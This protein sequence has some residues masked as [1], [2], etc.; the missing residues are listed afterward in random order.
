MARR[1]AKPAREVKK[2][3]NP[4][5]SSVETGQAHRGNAGVI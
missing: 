2:L 3:Y 1:N 5:T 4:V